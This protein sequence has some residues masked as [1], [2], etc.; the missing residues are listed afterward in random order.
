MNRTLQDLIREIDTIRKKQ[1]EAIQEM[2]NLGGRTGTSDLSIPKRKQ[3]MK[4]NS[5]AGDIIERNQYI[6]QR[7][8]NI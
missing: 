8:Y 6:S 7:K 4:E 3:D 2:E 1:T 5:S